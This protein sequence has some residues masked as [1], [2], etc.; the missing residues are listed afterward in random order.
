MAIFSTN[1]QFP[2]TTPI[3]DATNGWDAV[4]A[5]AYSTIN[6]DLAARQ[7]WMVDFVG[8]GPGIFDESVGANNVLDAQISNI[9]FATGGAGNTVQ[10]NLNIASLDLSVSASPTLSVTGVVATIETSLVFV[11]SPTTP[12]LHNLT[13]NTAS[14][15]TVT[16]VTA[17]TPMTPVQT[18][19]L[20]TILQSFVTS[21]S[22]IFTGV[23]ANVFTKDYAESVDIPWLLPTAFDYAVADKID[24]SPPTDGILAVL[25]SVSGDLTGLSAQV[26]PGIFPTN[27]G[28]NAATAISAAV[29][30]TDTFV[31]QLNSQLGSAFATFTFNA[32]TNVLTNQA[33][34]DAYYRIDSA[35]GE[36][37]LIPASAL[38]GSTGATYPF[39]IPAGGLTF[40]FAANAITAD[41]NNGV[42]TL[43]GGY[44]QTIQL[45][46]SYQLV[47]D[48]NQNIDIVL[49]GSP[50][51]VS[52]TTAPE[53]TSVG[54][55]LTDIGITA[56]SIVIGEA[57][58]FA[59]DKIT[60]FVSNAAM[61][62][63]TVLGLVR[64]FF[65]AE[66]Q[67]RVPGNGTVG[68]QFSI[69]GGRTVT[70]GAN[71][72]VFNQP[73]MPLDQSYINAVTLD[74]S[75]PF[76]GEVNELAVALQ[77]DG[78]A[79]NQSNV[80]FTAFVTKVLSLV[81][82][83][84][85]TTLLTTLINQLSDV[86]VD[87]N[88]AWFSQ[89]NVVNNLQKLTSLQSA[90][91]YEGCVSFIND[92]T[93]AGQLNYSVYG[94][95]IAEFPDATLEPALSQQTADGSV[96]AG[97]GATSNAV[98]IRTSA[99]NGTNTVTG[100][101][102][103]LQTAADT[104]SYGL[105]ATLFK[106]VIQS[107]DRPLWV[108]ITGVGLYLGGLVAGYF[109]EQTLS[110]LQSGPTSPTAAANTAQAIASGGPNG[111]STLLFSNVTFPFMTRFSSG[112]STGPVPANVLQCAAVNGGLVLGVAI[113]INQN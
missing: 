112:G 104:N 73:A 76:D 67:I 37:S 6:A 25:A 8:L 23:Y 65:A 99:G 68:V 102:N 57:L 70:L 98:C 10:M 82:G 14:G 12:G 2:S 4:Y 59:F 84:N 63:T 111:P 31:A 40:T 69:K 88:S 27:A 66:R 24:V 109:A 81:L 32:A 26:N 21:Q 100:L 13:V 92:A 52:T 72:N 38:A 51:I 54:A 58:A 45:S 97:R 42:V 36:V 94:T 7:P 96:F 77:G 107:T 78:Q 9:T 29:V 71:R 5:V 33:A 50:V 43:D 34:I 105:A 110:N 18:V 22:A 108:K 64:N 93:N 75:Y 53:T 60:G 62:N 46:T 74:P 80:R 41:I 61:S 106:D 28:V 87:A 39:T 79:G 20:Q 101:F 103:D 85:R 30:A 83:A 19:I 17:T 3:Q 48:S 44:T 91:L 11:A 55:V 89:S 15:L 86:D 56:G 47:V 16:G 49:S 35:T 1:C 95:L 113:A 90:A